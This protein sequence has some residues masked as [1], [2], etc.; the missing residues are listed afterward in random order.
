MQLPEEYALIGASG[1]ISFLSLTEDQ[2]Q[3]INLELD[4]AGFDQF[5]MPVREI[6]K[7][8]N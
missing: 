8:D 4:R 3:H 1:V 6:F 7:G 5:W 2:A